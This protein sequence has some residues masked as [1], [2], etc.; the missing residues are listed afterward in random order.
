MLDELGNPE[1]NWLMISIRC[2][3][4]GLLGR[5]WAWVY[6]MPWVAAPLILE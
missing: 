3:L 4:A 5:P 1:R 2:A 6:R